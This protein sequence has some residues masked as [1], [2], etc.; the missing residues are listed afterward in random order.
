MCASWWAK[1]VYKGCSP[2]RMVMY[3]RSKMKLSAVL[4]KKDLECS[5]PLSLTYRGP[6]LLMSFRGSLP[7]LSPFPPLGLIPG[8]LFLPGHLIASEKTLSPDNQ[9]LRCKDGWVG[10]LVCL[11]KWAVPFCSSC[12]IPWSAMVTGC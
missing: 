1:L 2:S 8:G 7:C 6:C 3:Y 12:A 10:G 4:E 9:L 5:R 11:I